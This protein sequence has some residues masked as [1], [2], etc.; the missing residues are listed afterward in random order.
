MF[1]AAGFTAGGFR[2]A[3][4]GGGGALGAGDCGGREPDGEGGGGGRFMMSLAKE[5]TVGSERDERGLSAAS[6][7]GQSITGF[8]LVEFPDGDECFKIIR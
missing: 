2:G 7:R 3:G 8:R 5:D 4:A 1:V 6:W